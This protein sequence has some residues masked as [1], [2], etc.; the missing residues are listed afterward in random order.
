MSQNS[1]KPLN[2]TI[3]SDYEAV[4]KQLAVLREDMAKLAETV[5]EIAGRRRSNMAED[6]VEGFEEARLYVERSGKSAEER[7]EGSISSNPLLAVGL[8]LMAGFMIGASSR[9]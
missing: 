2:D 6:I 9:R 1:K 7:L 3:A 4:S 5:S 8:A